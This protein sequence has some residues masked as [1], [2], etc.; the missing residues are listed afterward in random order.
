[1][2]LTGY[3]IGLLMIVPLGDLFEN[4]RLVLLLV[5]LE[6]LC[7]LAISLLACPIFFLGVAFLVGATA[8]AVQLL[9]PYASALHS[10]TP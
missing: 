7:L 1:L 2:P 4:R 10:P 9:V 3:G 8:A 5:G 6:A